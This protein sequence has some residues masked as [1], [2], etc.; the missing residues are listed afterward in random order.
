MRHN[1]F[2][3]DEFTETLTDLFCGRQQDPAT[4][5]RLWSLR[6]NVFEAAELIAGEVR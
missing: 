1:G 6:F 3:L 2:T 4:A 5:E